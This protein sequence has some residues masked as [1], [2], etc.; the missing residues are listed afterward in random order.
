MGCHA[1]VE[2]DLE[3]AWPPAPPG[4]SLSGAEIHVWQIP[5]DRAPEEVRSLARMLSPPERLRAR[6]FHF[7]RHGERFVVA[8]GALRQ[9]LGDYAMV[10]PQ[11]LVFAYGPRGKP[12]LA[13]G[14]EK[15]RFNLSH[16]HELALLAVAR[17]RELGIDLEKVRNL[18]TAERLA[19]RFFAPS[20]AAALRAL[21]AGARERA[22]FRCWTRK[23]AYVKA[24][25]EGLA[26]H[27]DRFEVSLDP[28]ASAELVRVAGD[29][30]RASSWFLRDLRPAPGFV[31]ALAVEGACTNL[32]YWRW[33][34]ANGTA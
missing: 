29:L 31:G 22:F 24:L 8:R 13:R 3:E 21:P 4:P 5:L 15:L 10:A 19:E 33:P 1:H 23:E 2:S 9:I 18:R 12:A 25:G 17:G 27:L 7:P 26:C 32:A 11:R 30:D 34:G 16:S 20:E 14:G 6:R 28:E